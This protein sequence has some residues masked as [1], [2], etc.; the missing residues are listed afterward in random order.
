MD[1]FKAIFRN[2]P[3]VTAGI[4]WV[5]AA[6]LKFLIILIVERRFNWERLLGTGGMPS[7]HTTPVVACTTSIGLVVGFDSPLFALAVVLSIIVGYDATGIRR[8]AGEQAK[9]ITNLIEDLTKGEMFKGQKPADFFHR[10]NLAELETLL[11]HNP[12]EVF[13]G[14]LLGI[15]VALVVH[16]RYGYFFPIPF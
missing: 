2:E 16:Y 12:I 3:L 13:V 10:W 5:V 14:I 11:G 15:L 1:F 7:T 4:S 6:F 9:A 8:H